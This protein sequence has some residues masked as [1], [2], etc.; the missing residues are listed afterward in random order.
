MQCCGYRSISAFACGECDDHSCVQCACSSL[1]YIEKQNILLSVC[2]LFLFFCC[3]FQLHEAGCFYDLHRQLIRLASAC[4]QID[5]CTLLVLPMKNWFLRP[6]CPYRSVVHLTRRYLLCTCTITAVSG[7]RKS[8][9]SS[10]VYYLVGKYGNLEA[11][12]RRLSHLERPSSRLFTRTTSARERQILK[13][14]VRTYRSYWD[15]WLSTFAK[16]RQAPCLA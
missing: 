10:A 6:L 2:R 5:V 7:T 3:C 16:T 1:S 9:F 4:T 14:H 15:A 13:Y 12:K 11:A 8:D